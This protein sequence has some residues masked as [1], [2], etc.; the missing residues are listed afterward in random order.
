MKK[1]IIVIVALFI[2]AGFFSSC[3]ELK[4]MAKDADKVQRTVKPSPLEMHA[5]KVGVDVSITFPAKYFGKHVKLVIMPALVTS[6]GT[7]SVSFKPQTLHGEKFEDKG[8]EI[9]YAN[10]GSFKFSDT[11][12]YDAKYRNS[13]LVLNFVASTSKGDKPKIMRFPLGDKGKGVI[14]TPEL[15]QKGLE[16][17]AGANMA[18][19]VEATITKP[20]IRADQKTAEIYFNVQ[21]AS[22][23]GKEMKKAEIDSLIAFIV[24]ASENPDLELKAIKI[25]SYASPDG[26]EELNEGLVNK[27]GTNSQKAFINALKK[28]KFNKATDFVVTATTPAEDWEGFKRLVKASDLDDKDN[29]IQVVN[30]HTDPVKR[31]AEIKKISRVYNKLRKVIL[32]MLR[33]SVFKLEYQTK[34]RTNTELMGMASSKPEDLS[35]SELLYSA[36]LPTDNAAKEAIY[37]TYTSKYPTDWKAWNNLGIAQAMQS[38]FSDAKV[39]F[40]KVLDIDSNN[41][42]AFNNL[43]AIALAEG[44][45][46]K[47]WEYFEKAESAGCNS[48]SLGYNMGVILIKQAKY[49]EAVTKFGGENTFNKALALVL[50]GQFDAA[51]STVNSMGTKSNAIFYYLKAVVAAKLDVKGDVFENLRLA[52]S[53]DSSLK[54]YAGKDLEF[55][56]YFEDSEFKAIVK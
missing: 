55:R 32:P 37:K 15:V 38:K 40:Q 46:A 26:S 52:T 29:I 31:E 47:A 18:K 24:S 53:K 48:S 4:K 19:T 10:G 9:S 14:T 11:I 13:E 28:A 44:D 39:S 2:T 50:T 23:K 41:G 6:D 12:D 49:D 35:Q 22:V 33:R 8:P 25:S 36:T 42:A 54:E 30:M 43:G 56:K 17:D 21:N 51:K 5:N 45:D 34:A 20:A 27:R 3:D 1:T 7:D 16:V